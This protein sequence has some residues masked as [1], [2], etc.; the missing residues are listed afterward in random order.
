MN[1]A[2]ALRAALLPTAGICILVCLPCNVVKVNDIGTKN[3]PIET[4][5]LNADLAVQL[6]RK[7]LRHAR[8]SREL[9]HTERCLFD[10]LAHGSAP[11]MYHIHVFRRHAAMNQHAH[12]LLHHYRDSACALQS[13]F[14]PHHQS[15]TQLQAGD[16]EREIERCHDRD[17]TE[18]PAIASGLLSCVVARGMNAAGIESAVVTAEVFEEV[19][20]DFHLVPGLVVGLRHDTRDQPC[21]V[22]HHFRARQLV[23][24]LVKDLAIHNISLRVLQGIVQAGLRA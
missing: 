3:L 16:F 24:G 22:V 10:Q 12:K 4:G 2:H 9:C 15:T 1:E 11:T 19:S 21:E 23:T 6:F 14:V 20:G 5:I 17:G 7:I 13:G 8:G 18:G